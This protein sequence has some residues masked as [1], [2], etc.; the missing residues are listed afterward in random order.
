MATFST[1]YGATSCQPDQQF[2]VAMSPWIHE[3]LPGSPNWLAA[4]QI[5]SGS[6]VRATAFHRNNNSLI[7]TAMPARNRLGAQALRKLFTIGNVLNLKI[8]CPKPQPGLKHRILQWKWPHG[9]EH[10]SDGSPVNIMTHP[11]DIWWYSHFV[12]TEHQ[13]S[14]FKATLVYPLYFEAM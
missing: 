14:G 8:G 6:R 2:A 10:V 12:A 9:C 5:C 7:Q 3:G 1:C 11:H 4:P 13:K